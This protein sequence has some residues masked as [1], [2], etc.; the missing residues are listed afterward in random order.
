MNDNRDL[1]FQSTK[2]QDRILPEDSFGDWKWREGLAESMIP[3]IGGLYRNGIN[4]LIYGKSL[5]NL[6][7]VEIMKA[8]RF[9]RQADNNELSELETFPILEYINSLNIADCEIDVGELAIKFPNFSE[10]KNNTSNEKKAEDQDFP[11]LE[12]FATLTKFQFLRKRFTF[13]QLKTIL[14]DLE[15]YYKKYSYVRRDISEILIRGH[16]WTADESTA[17]VFLR[18]NLYLVRK[19]IAENE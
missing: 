7:P 17:F 4:I 2:R 13:I 8:H 12:Y 9:A 1:S 16:L 18:A 11:S 10:I 5:V 14:D 15:F 6:S 3:I 19:I